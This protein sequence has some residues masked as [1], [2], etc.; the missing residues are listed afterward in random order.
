M[1]KRKDVRFGLILMVIGLLSGCGV[2]LYFLLSGESIPISMLVAPAVF[3]LLGLVIIFFDTLESNLML[4]DEIEECAELIADDLEDLRQGR[5]TTTHAM[6]LITLAVLLGHIVTLFLFRKWQAAWGGFLNVVGV[7]AIAGFVMAY[8]GIRTHW[9]QVRK[10]RLSW[11]I[12]LIPLGAYA[13]SAILGIYFAEPKV[14][15][16]R[17][18]PINQRAD[19]AYTWGQTRGSEFYMSDGFSIGEIGGFDCDDEAC[20][21]LILVVI[22]IICVVASATIPHF[23]VVAT[24]ILWTIM[25]LITTRELLCRGE[26][27]VGSLAASSETGE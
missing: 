7:A 3:F 4:E 9:F 21:V 19:Y 12:Y 27:P 2:A 18:L 17:E 25:L 1:L 8:I 13:L 5:F 15:N 26:V 16:V 22:A 10:V 24:T 20:L 23:W 11:S 14:Q 6:V